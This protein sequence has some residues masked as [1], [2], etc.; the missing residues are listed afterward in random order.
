MSSLPLCIFLAMSMIH[1]SPRL[2]LLNRAPMQ[3]S[4]TCSM[5]C[6]QCGA[7]ALKHRNPLGFADTKLHGTQ[8]F[9]TLSSTWPSVQV[10][11]VARTLSNMP[12]SAWRI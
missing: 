10:A 7:S 4:R 8:L 5:I 12:R 11:Y 2:Q 6:I 1:I 9:T 3:A